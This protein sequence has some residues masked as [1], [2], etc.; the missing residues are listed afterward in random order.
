MY[1]CLCWLYV[2]NEINTKYDR[3]E[4]NITHDCIQM[5]QTWKCLYA[6]STFFADDNICFVSPVRTL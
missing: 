2:P 1:L 4:I 5:L 6:F 3:D